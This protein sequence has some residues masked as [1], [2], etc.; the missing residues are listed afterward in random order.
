MIR[1]EKIFLIAV[2][3]GVSALVAHAQPAIS[4]MT[5]NLADAYEGYYKTKEATDKLSDAHA[6]AMEQAEA[7]NQEGLLRLEWEIEQ[8]SPI[9]DRY[10]I[11]TDYHLTLSYGESETPLPEQLKGQAT[12]TLVQNV[13]L[14]YEISIWQDLKSDSLPCWSDLKTL[15]Q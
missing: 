8:L 9:D 2:A 13:D 14:L 7:L 6:K 11:I 5:V 12:L 4:V 1:L 3:V 10:E 15:V